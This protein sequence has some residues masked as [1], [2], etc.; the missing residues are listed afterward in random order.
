[1]PEIEARA[2]AD[3]IISA[4]LGGE[5]GA[6]ALVIGVHVGIERVG[7]AC[8]RARE[9]RLVNFDGARRI[10]HRSLARGEN[11]VRQAAFAAPI[12]LAKLERLFSAARNGTLTASRCSP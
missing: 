12:E 9:Q 11:D 6:A 4:Q 1:M 2:G 8:A 7:E 5:R 10:D 3:K